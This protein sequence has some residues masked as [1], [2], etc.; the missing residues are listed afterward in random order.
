MIFPDILEL[1][2]GCNV[3]KMNSW[4]C[5]DDV[6]VTVRLPFPQPAMR[7][8]SQESEILC[9]PRVVFVYARA[10]GVCLHPLHIEFKRYSACLVSVWG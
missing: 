4:S 9:S 8:L 1:A 7:Q 3:K 2:S 5:G 6:D 10:A